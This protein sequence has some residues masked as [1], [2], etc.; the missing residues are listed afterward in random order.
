MRELL[1]PKIIPQHIIEETREPVKPSTVIP[2]L[3][4]MG[5]SA[6]GQA[7]ITYQYRGHEVI[8]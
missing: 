5:S 7:Q 2:E 1:D 4:L 3:D 6:Y 8:Q